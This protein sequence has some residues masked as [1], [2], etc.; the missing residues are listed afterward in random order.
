MG[1][2]AKAGVPEVGRDRLAPP[3]TP[4]RRAWSRRRATEAPHHSVS[5]RPRPTRA[6]EGLCVTGRTIRRSLLFACVASAAAEADDG[7]M[8][9]PLPL[10]DSSSAAPLENPAAPPGVDVPPAVADRPLGLEDFERIALATNPTVAQAIDRFE[11]NRG[12]A[13]QAGA[14]PNPLIIW[15]AQTLGDEGTVGRQQGYIQQPIITGG[16]LRVNRARYEVDVETSRWAVH[17]QRMLVTN[18]VRMRY[19]QI[20]ALQRMIRLRIDLMRFAE[21]VA[22][23]TGEKIESGH[24]S[25]PDLLMAENEVAQ[26]RLS[27]DHL[28]ERHLNSWREFAAFIGQPDL[29]PTPL[30]GSLEGELRDLSWDALLDRLLRESPELRVAQLQVRRQALTL[31]LERR[32]PI[33]DLVIRGGGGHNPTDGQ[34]TGYA[35]VYVEL[36][37]WDRNR[38]NIHTARNGLVEFRRDVERVRLNLQQRLARDFNHH[39]TSLANVR[40][41][42]D[43]ILPRARRAFDLYYKSFLEEDASY[44]RVE[45]SRSAYTEAFIKYVEELLELRRAEVAIEGLELVEETVEVGTLRPPASGRLVPPGE[46]V[47][48]YPAGGGVPVGRP[49]RTGG[50]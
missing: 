34:T 44:S 3:R 32:E 38:G 17:Q 10:P 40:R 1:E 8:A 41:Y 31:E 23:S 21:N 50:P 5:P 43:E 27:L 35:Q 15:G 4:P 36:P 11:Q 19:L 6:G 26:M 29:P 24:A 39:Q 22:R 45:S 49:T 18:G 30:E 16:K 13:I 9:L 7:P 37:L 48:H 2:G 33:P 14:Y 47:G 28:R 12:R 25:E 46:G 42:R 20:L